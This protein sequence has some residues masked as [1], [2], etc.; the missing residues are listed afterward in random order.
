MQSFHNAGGMILRGPG[1]EN[2][3]NYP[4][5]DVTVYDEGH[6]HWSEQGHDLAAELLAEFLRERGLL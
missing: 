6:G 2:Y 4:R 3:G 1:A 5:A